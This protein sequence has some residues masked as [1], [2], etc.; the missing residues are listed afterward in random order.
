[1]G[2]TL[3]L[4]EWLGLLADRTWEILELTFGDISGL[5]WQ[6]QMNLSPSRSQYKHSWEVLV[7]NFRTI[8]KTVWPRKKAC[9]LRLHITWLLLDSFPSTNQWGS[10]KNPCGHRSVYF[11]LKEKWLSLN[12]LCCFQYL[13][14]RWSFQSLSSFVALQLSA[15]LS[16]SPSLQKSW[17]CCHLEMWVGSFVIAAGSS[18]HTPHFL[19][20]FSIY[21]PLSFYFLLNTFHIWQSGSYYHFLC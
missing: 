5:L 12:P 15:W 19:F 9:N 17:N 14:S 3:W 8:S 20:R 13:V 16:K 4:I 6:T 11:C 2:S 21:L 18:F 1:M 10:Q 7:M